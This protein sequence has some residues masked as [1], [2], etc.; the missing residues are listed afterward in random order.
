MSKDLSAEQLQSLKYTT[1]AIQVQ[2]STD[3]ARYVLSF[4]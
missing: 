4:K 1:G 3:V 2:T